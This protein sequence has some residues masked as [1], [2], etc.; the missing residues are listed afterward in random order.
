MSDIILTP[1]ALLGF[2][3]EI[4]ELK[5]KEITFNETEDSLS[6]VIGDSEYI[7]DASDAPEVEMDEESFEQ[8]QDANEDG[9]EELGDSIE[10]VDDVEDVEGGVLKEL[11]K[12]LALGG[13]IRMTKHA[14]E[15]A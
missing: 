11:V 10:D 1:S 8:V 13:L 9:Y 12:T 5:D 3:S 2:L 14:L 6:V 7:L 4:E 15:R